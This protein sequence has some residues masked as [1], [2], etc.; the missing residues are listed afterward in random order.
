MIKYYK[1]MAMPAG[2][3]GAETENNIQRERQTSDSGEGCFCVQYWMFRKEI[4][5]EMMK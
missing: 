3:Y 2:L 5:S 4:G 1:T